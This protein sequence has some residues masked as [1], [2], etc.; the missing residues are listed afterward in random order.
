MSKR[1]R[2]REM[3]LQMLYQSECGRSAGS[4]VLARFDPSSFGDDN[5]NGAG[6]DAGRRDGR[7]LEYARELFAGTIEHQQEID[8]LIR[9]QAEHWRLER[10]PAVDRNI[11]RL[12]AFEFLY[13]VDVP[14]LV[15]INEAIELAKRF[16]SEDSGRFVNGLLDGLLKSHAFP[17]ALT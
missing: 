5:K 15:V 17:G 16:G 1:R 3:A 4:E 9:S 7:A 8:S 12:A 2:G 14:K 10:M 13:E 11:L 6:A